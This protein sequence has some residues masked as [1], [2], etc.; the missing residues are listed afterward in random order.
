[1]ISPMP[2][3]RGQRTPRPGCAP[4]RHGPGDREP[5][6]RRTIERV[7]APRLAALVLV[8]AALDVLVLV[9]PLP[10]GLPRAYLADVGNLTAAVLGTVCAA[11][12]ARRTDRWLHGSWLAL[13]A[14]GSAWSIGQLLWIGLT[15][16]D[17]YAFPSPADAAFLLFPPLAG[18]ALLLY[19]TETGAPWLRRMFDAG[20]TT[21]ALGLLGGRVTQDVM[22]WS[23]SVDS[24]PARAVVLA[25]PSLD[26][27]L[28]AL[29]VFTLARTAT[30]R[31]PLGLITGGLLTF[32][33]ADITFVYQQAAGDNPLNV[34]DAGWSLGFG[35]IALAATV[36]PGPDR[37]T[38]SLPQQFPLTGLL[39]YL[40]VTAVLVV[41]TST[42]L[43]GQ[44]L[45]LRDLALIGAL[46]VLLLARQY[47]AL[48]QNWRLT[49][50]LAQR[51]EQLRQQAFHDGLTG[52]ANR[53][54]FADR[55][56]HAVHLHARDLRPV[57]LLFLDLDDFKIVNDT[58]GHAAGDQLLIRVAERLR[59]TTRAGDTVARLGG[60]EFAVLLEDGADPYASAQRIADSLTSPFDVEQ[61][62]VVVRVS[63]G[64]V[65]LDPADA[66]VDADELLA[67][68]DTAMYAAKRAGKARIV[69]HTPG[70]SLVELEEQRLRA[71]LRRAIADG[72]IQLAYQ[73]IVD[74]GTERIIALEA[75][76]RWRYEDADVPPSTVQSIAARSAM[77]PDLTTALLTE[78]C[79]QLAEWSAA[80]PEDVRPLGVHINVA[81]GQLCA[82]GF[83]A[84]VVGLVD[85]H[86]LRPGQLVLEITESGSVADLATV[87]SALAA[88][89][90]AGVAVA[91]DDFGVGYASLS[92]LTDIE[93]DSVKIAGSFLDRLE[94]D[95][96]Q[97][98]FLRGLLG[99]AR[100]I[101]LPVIADGVERPAQLAELRRLGCPY[102][103]GYLLGR[104]AFAP[105]T[106]TLLGLGRSVPST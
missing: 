96:R 90:R 15:W 48:R 8:V 79:A 14:A 85:G 78:A 89:R 40:P 98:A 75:L 101:A 20:M 70:M 25:Y 97:A 68:A 37:A 86:R 100:G 80:W 3:R 36:R 34:I 46:V 23:G 43:E 69:G 82:D 39:P 51:E 84:L 74:L 4:R 53:A 24:G 9:A 7:E 50:Q 102:A 28:L 72:A 1:M 73:P 63:I 35:C 31:L 83:V 44:A 55:L 16:S 5:L 27:V 62:P 71:V 57:S 19:P 88:L 77:L 92:R 66:G 32:V 81:P 99:L 10:S 52:L 49:I 58:L 87:R 17:T 93:L 30:A 60:D 13:T 12:R 18:L 106:T 103:Q 41:A 61:R 76:A 95:S 105:A 26:V 6:L 104:P 47:L 45:P 33:A 65:E 29:T 64:V 21:L 38:E 54:L 59:G 42:Q 91:L 94:T 67:R 22:G 11:W 2:S 56:E